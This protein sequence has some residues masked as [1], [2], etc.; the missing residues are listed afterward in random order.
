MRL[1]LQH[2]R[3]GRQH[4]R[5]CPPTPKLGRACPPKPGRRRECLRTALRTRAALLLVAALL[6][7]CLG[8]ASA[9]AAS[10]AIFFP[11]FITGMGFET[12][13]VLTNASGA[14]ATVILT[15]RGDDGRVLNQIGRAHV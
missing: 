13:L 8:A 10:R 4:G 7:V 5:V 11:H 9:Q 1:I 15:A 12:R 3:D 2:K 14:P 6:A